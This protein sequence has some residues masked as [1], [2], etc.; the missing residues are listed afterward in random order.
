MNESHDNNLTRNSLPGEEGQSQKRVHTVNA[1]VSF[2]EGIFQY[3][4]LKAHLSFA[5]GER[6]INSKRGLKF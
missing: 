5:V 4:S 6:G 2:W 1:E 3:V